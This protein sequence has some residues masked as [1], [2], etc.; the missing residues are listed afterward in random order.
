MGSF[1]NVVYIVKR[2]A[3]LLVIGVQYLLLWTRGA[4]DIHVHLPQ[5]LLSD[6]SVTDTVIDSYC[7]LVSSHCSS[8]AP[9]TAAVLHLTL[10]LRCTSH[11]SSAEPH[12]AAVLHLIQQQCCTS[13]CLQYCCTSHCSSPTPTTLDNK[14]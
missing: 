9:H 10:K 2:E 3:L 14:Q 6:V 7:L 1:A 12:T 13:H 5:L 8:A 4:G 11:F